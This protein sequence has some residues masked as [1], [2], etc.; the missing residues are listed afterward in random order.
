MENAMNKEDLEHDISVAKPVWDGTTFVYTLAGERGLTKNDLTILIKCCEYFD[1]YGALRR[2]P[3]LPERL[4]NV[5]K[6]YGML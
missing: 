1:E 5:L 3:Y 2:V 4:L 6:H